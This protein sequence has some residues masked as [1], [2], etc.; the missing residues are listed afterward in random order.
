MMIDS[1]SQTKDVLALQKKMKVLRDA[2][3]K[4][5]Q[6]KETAV[7]LKNEF[8]AEVERLRVQISEKV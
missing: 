6:E 8:S 2:V 7:K 3:I 1:R 4:E 5:R